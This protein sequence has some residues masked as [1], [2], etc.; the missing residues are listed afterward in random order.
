[1]TNSKSNAV[2]HRI[3]NAFSNMR[4]WKDYELVL[5]NLVDF[6]EGKHIHTNNGWKQSGGHSSLI[7][8]VEG[9]KVL[10]IL[11]AVNV[12]VVFGNDAARGG[13]VGAYFKCARKNTAAA[14][15]FA[16]LLFLQKQRLNDFFDK[17]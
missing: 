10:K 17:D 11:K 8:N 5:S 2:Q 15:F 14:T 6:F 12:S 3:M 7:A 9:R 4:N 1:M 16:D 13:A